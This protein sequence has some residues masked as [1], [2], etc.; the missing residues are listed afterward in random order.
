MLW[1][2]G[3]PAPL[4]W[5]GSGEGPSFHLG[6]S[7]QL[8]CQP[9]HEIM[10]HFPPSGSGVASGRI[11]SASPLCWGA[12]GLPRREEKWGLEGDGEGSAESSNYNRAVLSRVLLFATPWTVA[13][14]A[15]LSMG[16][17]RQEYW[18]GLPCPL[19]GDFP[20]PG[21]KPTSRA[22]VDGL[23]TVHLGSPL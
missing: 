19:P 9:E 17:S 14:Q 1:W 2:Q 18:S 13:R 21:I 6:A 12:G 10:T 7:A 15:P 4:G 22:L 23:F 8:K 3:S 5:P 11:P 20:D 16:F